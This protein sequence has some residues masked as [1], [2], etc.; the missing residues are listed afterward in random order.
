MHTSCLS[1]ERR[2][3]TE[4]IIACLG[5]SALT[6]CNVSIV[7]AVVS[8]LWLVTIYCACRDFKNNKEYLTELNNNENKPRIVLKHIIPIL[9]SVV[10]LRS[11]L[12]IAFVTY[13]IARSLFI[14]KNAI[15][16]KWVVGR[17][18][19]IDIKEES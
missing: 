11:S 7:I 6:D 4:L 16:R 5:L 8:V 18:K 19:I 2:S 17:L 9:V 14:V 13:V 1:C 3:M 12:P 10:L 15:I